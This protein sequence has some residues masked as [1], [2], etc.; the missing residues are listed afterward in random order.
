MV[1][2]PV[3]MWKNRVAHRSHLNLWGGGRPGWV[4]VGGLTAGFPHRFFVE[5]KRQIFVF[6]PTRKRNLYLGSLDQHPLYVGVMKTHVL[7]QKSEFS[8]A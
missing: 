8:P 4:Y 7:G 6:S 1:V 5:R 2:E 3:E